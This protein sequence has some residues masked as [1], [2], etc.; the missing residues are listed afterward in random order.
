MDYSVW[1]AGFDEV[2]FDVA[3]GVVVEEFAERGV[4]DAGVE[5]VFQ[6]A[7]GEGLGEGGVDDVDA[8]AGFVGVE[9][10]GDEEAGCYVAHD[11]VA[12]GLGGHVRLDNF[13]VFMFGVEVLETV[14]GR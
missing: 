8:A 14:F 9:A 7:A 4:Q 11:A 6:L 12:I 10:G 3:F 5:E 13:D 2:F 1:E